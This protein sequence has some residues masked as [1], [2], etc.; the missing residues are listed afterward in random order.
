VGE[1]PADELY[2]VGGH[3]V[4]GAD[5]MPSQ[6]P[7]AAA[8]ARRDPRK[9]IFV[10]GGSAAFGYPWPHA[11]TYA[12]IL[13]ERLGDRDY[14]VLN[15]S[16]LGWTS[17]EL[18]PVVRAIAADF[19]PQVVVLFLGNNEWT[20][21]RPDEAAG[22]DPAV[23]EL[24]D[25]LA[26]S[27]LISL[28]IYWRLKSWEEREREAPRET[29]GGY[30]RHQEMIGCSYAIRHPMPAFDGARWEELRAAFLDQF[31]SNLRVLVEAA[32]SGGA[33]VVLCTLPFRYRLSPAWKH[34]QPL[35]YDEANRE[36]VTSA[37]EAARSALGGGDCAAALGVLDRALQ[38]EPRVPVLL[39]LKAKALEEAGRPAE[40]EEWYARARDA[41][42]GNLGGIVA[43]NECIRRV[44]GEEGA[45]LVDLKVG[46]DR[47]QHELGGWFNRDLIVDDCHPTL[48]GQR[49]IAE[50]LTPAVR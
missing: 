16:Q 34:R 14:R 45:T 36:L 5:T 11:K 37:I 8:D 9:K 47:R 21:W 6:V 28:F 7:Y 20:R 3:E 40:A 25:R 30:E 24:Y 27:R 35:C 12:A 38:R 19:S 26:G 15:A 4:P 48:A 10:V 2:K 32:R 39:Y 22:L 49:L 50:L 31:E 18:V 1:E 33:R 23:L 29:G 46:F 17:G 42:V 13:G 41:V 43:I 44:A